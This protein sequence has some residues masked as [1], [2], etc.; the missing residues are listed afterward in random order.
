MTLRLVIVFVAFYD[1]H[2]FIYYGRTELGNPDPL[3][4]I[5][6]NSNSFSN[7]YGCSYTAKLKSNF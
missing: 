5:D 3:G 2:Y 4:L 6:A 1:F 7:L